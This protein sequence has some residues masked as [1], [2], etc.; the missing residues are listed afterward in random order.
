MSTRI[1][2]KVM[3]CFLVLLAI[4]DL[5]NVGTYD[6]RYT[7]KGEQIS[8]QAIIQSTLTSIPLHLKDSF[9]LY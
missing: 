1:K 3:T 4:K 5:D 7:Q 6:P 2:V 8:K 9:H